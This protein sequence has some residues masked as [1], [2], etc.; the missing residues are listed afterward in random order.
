[1]GV[2]KELANMTVERFKDM[3]ATMIRELIG[4]SGLDEILD[5]KKDTGFDVMELMRAPEWELIRKTGKIG[6]AERVFG[7]KSGYAEVRIVEYR[8]LVTDDISLRVDFVHIPYVLQEAIDRN[9]SLSIPGFGAGVSNKLE[10]SQVPM[11]ST[12]KPESFGA[13]S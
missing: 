8:E 3:I 5:H 9:Q 2:K 13:F 12:P 1:M 11:A 6:N 10:E 7:H 4:K